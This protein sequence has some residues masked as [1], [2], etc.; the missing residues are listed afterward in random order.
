MSGD[1]ALV[2]LV[3]VLFALVSKRIGPTVISGPMVFVAAGLLL[4][5]E[6]ADSVDLGLE[7]EAVDLLGEFTLAIL[8]FSDAS[9]IDTR[10]LPLRLAHRIAVNRTVAGVHF[11]VD[12]RAGGYLGCLAGEIVYAIANGS[13]LPRCEVDMGEAH[14]DFLLSNFNFEADGNGED[15]KKGAEGEDDSYKAH[16]VLNELWS[17]AAEEWSL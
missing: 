10:A 14:E 2:A 11:P 6:V 5:P 16:S 12:S 9:R 17:K 7:L 15:S 8:L 4:G 1:V 13:K 3:V